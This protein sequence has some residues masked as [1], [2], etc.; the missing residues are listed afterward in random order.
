MEDYERIRELA[1]LRSEIAK[2][3]RELK[4]L[5]DNCPHNSTEKRLQGADS[6]RV[7]IV[8]GVAV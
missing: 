8:C 7:C 2:M 1:R 6:Y 3:Q 5:L 4:S